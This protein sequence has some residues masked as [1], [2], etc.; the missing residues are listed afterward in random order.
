MYTFLFLM[1]YKRVF[2]RT[3]GMGFV[4]KR[5]IFPKFFGVS[6]NFTVKHDHL[7]ADSP[8]HPSW[9]LQVGREGSLLRARA[10]RVRYGHQLP[11]A[12]MPCAWHTC[13]PGVVEIMVATRVHSGAEWS[14]ESLFF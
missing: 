1:A 12:E 2:V 9:P 5:W 7:L 13:K 8:G 10:K 6:L 3:C 4:H 11:E 14:I